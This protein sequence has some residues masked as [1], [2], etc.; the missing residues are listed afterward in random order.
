VAQWATSTDGPVV[1]MIG[2]LVSQDPPPT[3]GIDLPD[4]PDVSLG[5]HLF[6]SVQWVFFAAF[7]LV[8][9]VLLL[10]R[11]ATADPQDRVAA[12]ASSATSPPSTTDS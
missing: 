1:A 11:E 4:P 5:P 10:R 3:P 6:Y 2:D 12:A 7:A 8:G 9:Y